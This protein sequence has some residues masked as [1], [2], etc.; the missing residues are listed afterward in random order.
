MLANRSRAGVDNIWLTR[1]KA[2]ME[3]EVALTLK[4]MT[5][6]ENTVR[7]RKATARYLAQL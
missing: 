2:F 1:M 4:V 7:G 5:I 6:T 3:P